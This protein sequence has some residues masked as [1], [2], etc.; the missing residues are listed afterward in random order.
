VGA[1]FLAIGPVVGG[2]LTQYFSWR[3]VF[4][5]NV[6]ISFIGLVLTIISVP[7]SKKKNEAFDFLGFFG[8]VLGV[9]GLITALMQGKYWGWGS[10]PVLTMGLG[11]IAMIVLLLL[12][13][14]R[15]K[16]PFIDLSLFRKRNY[17]VGNFCIFCIQFILILTV[18]WAIYFQKVLGYTPSFAGI[19]SMIACSPVIFFGAVGGHLFDRYGAKLPV[20]I[21][22]CL[23][24][25]AI[26]WFVLFPTPSSSLLLIPVVLP[27][28]C[29]IPLIIIPCF[30]LFLKSVSH[31]KRGVAVGISTAIRQLGATT[32]MA[33]FGAFFLSQFEKSF[34][35][36]M[37]EEA[38]TAS[39]NPHAFE[40][41]LSQAPKAVAALDSLEPS[42][43]ARVKEAFFSS[44]V[45]ASN[46]LNILGLALTVVALVLAFVLL[47]RGRNN[48]DAHSSK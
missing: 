29:G 3:Y 18:F 46:S 9:G 23:V 41:L 37:G 6:P 36:T 26:F 2:L 42:M 35:Q 15:V 16:D 40:G 5:I 1:F 34:Y 11:G 38:H 31:E 30:A 25:F 19:W 21:G 33:I 12:S 44:T 13:E 48:D 7:P 24:A 4:W 39:L 47:K 27:F 45:F 20:I 22:F 10:W 28:G 14:G 32:G 8:L 43:A 17:T